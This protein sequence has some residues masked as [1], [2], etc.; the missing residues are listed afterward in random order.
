VSLL[1]SVRRSVEFLYSP[2]EGRFYLNQDKLYVVD[3]S[4]IIE[5]Y[6]ASDS[7]NVQSSQHSESIEDMVNTIMIVDANGAEVGRVSNDGDFSAYG[8]LQEVYKVDAKQNTATAAKAMLKTVAFKSSLSAVGNVQCISGYAV[9]VQ[10]EQ[11]KGIFTI[12]SDRHTIANGVHLMELDLEFLKAV[13][14]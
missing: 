6:T 9:T 5:K 14:S 10:E 11:L 2:C 12:K 1:H 3:H 4:E 7:V 13:S 8:S